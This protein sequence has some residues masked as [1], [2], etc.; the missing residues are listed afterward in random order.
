MEAQGSGN[1][2][3]MIYRKCWLFNPWSALKISIYIISAKSLQMRTSN[4]ERTQQQKG[5]E[6]K[7]QTHIHLKLSNMKTSL[8]SLSGSHWAR[9]QGK[10]DLCSH[11]YGSSHGLRPRIW[12]AAEVQQNLNSLPPSKLQ[13]SPTKWTPHLPLSTHVHRLIILGISFPFLLPDLSS[14]GRN[15]DKHSNCYV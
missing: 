4:T 8:P 11:Q 13:G 10:A 5:Q 7:R 15:Y 9:T 14:C 3:L 2:L 1:S 6:G 12:E